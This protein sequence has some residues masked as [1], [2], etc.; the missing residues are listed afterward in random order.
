MVAVD[1]L[2]RE[3]DCSRLPWTA[4]S[5]GLGEADSA[6]GDGSGVM[7]AR[8]P[9]PGE[10]IAEPGEREFTLDRECA[11][12]NADPTLELR[13]RRSAFSRIFGGASSTRGN[14]ALEILF[15]LDDSTEAVLVSNC[16]PA[17]WEI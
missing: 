1:V 12:E 17:V 11:P 2:V 15:L 14:G 3:V 6:I 13:N 9:T 5:Q 16:R 4:R 8:G 10:E 7:S